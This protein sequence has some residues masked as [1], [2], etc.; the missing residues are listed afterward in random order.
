MNKEDIEEKDNLLEN[1]KYQ[2]EELTKK[3]EKLILI[4]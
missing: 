1:K 3:F 4:L 2:E